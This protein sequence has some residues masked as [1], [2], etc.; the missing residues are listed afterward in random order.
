MISSIDM[1]YIGIICVLLL[2]AWTSI[3]V[4]NNKKLPPGPIPL[5]LIGNLHNIFGAS[6]HKSMERLA[7][8]YGPILSLKLGR[9]PTVVISSSTVAKEAV[10]KHDSAFSSKTPKNAVEAHNHHKF[11]IVWLPID[12]SRR[13]SLRTILNS[14]I[15]TANKLDANQDLRSTKISE[16]IASC[17]RCSQTGD[18]VDFGIAASDIAINVLSNTIFSADLVDL[19]AKSEKKFKNVIRSITFQIGKFNM[20]DYFPVLKWID[21]QGINR[22]ICADF[23]KMFRIFGDFIDERLEQRKKNQKTKDVL[24]ILLNMSEEKDGNGEGNIAM[25]TSTHILQDLFIAGTDSSSATLEWAMLE[26]MKNPH[27]MKKAKAELTQVIGKKEA[28]KEADLVRLPYLHCILKETLRIHPPVPLLS[29]KAE[30]EFELC[31]YFVPKGSQVIVNI[32]SIGR[33][34]TIWED[35]LVF[36][37]ERFWGSNVMD[38][39]GQDDFKLIPFGVGR[40]MCPAI[41][42]AMRT[43]PI[44]LGSLLNSFDW[45]VEGN[46]D[47]DAEEKSGLIVDK[48]RPLR[49]VSISL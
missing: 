17:H 46:D 25:A 33:D 8:K 21:P 48:L 14:C 30:Q 39:R 38:I 3:R 11:S 24:D 15:V 44:M 34:P 4:P 27:A 45:V 7:N 37:P 10:K 1:Y 35:P 22:S 20:V 9:L 16:L 26:L 19:C 40:R 41:S 12:S 42:L 47:L 43:V 49:L 28:I 6:P 32:W 2:L 29:R 13:R 36:K 23:A 18:A 31:G 5:P